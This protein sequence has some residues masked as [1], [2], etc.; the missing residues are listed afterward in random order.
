MVS[1]DD[2]FLI[3][4]KDF[5]VSDTV[6]VFN[7]KVGDIL[8]FGELNYYRAVSAFVCSPQDFK[9]Q[10]FDMGVDFESLNRFEFFF[11]VQLRGITS[12]VSS[13]LFGDVDFGKLDLY[14]NPI[15][16]DKMLKYDDV[17]FDELSYT[18]ISEFI[19]RIN[20]LPIQKPEKYLDEATK[21]Y[22]LETE[23]N[24]MRHKKKDESFKPQLLP[25]VSA[26]VNSGHTSYTYDSIM[27]VRIS[28]LYDSVKRV[29]KIMHYGDV[30]G[31]LYAGTLQQDKLNLA[32][33]NWLS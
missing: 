9:V 8:D 21:R 33:I 20:D 5:K 13:I 28:Q 19:R 14:V 15:T 12:E 30:M 31:G 26:L 25:I 16:G 23:R 32:E 1:F 10:L 24:N 17:V 7:P 3:R 11:T 6:T 2:S 27:D 29:Q 4:G 18:L 22:V